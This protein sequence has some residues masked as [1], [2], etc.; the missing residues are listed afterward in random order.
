MSQ[1]KQG[2]HTEKKKNDCGCGCIGITEK[3]AK[4]SNPAAEKPKK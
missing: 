4:G 2:H 3:K 1:E